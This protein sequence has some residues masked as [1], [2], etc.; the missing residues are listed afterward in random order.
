M[1]AKDTPGMKLGWQD[2][3][4]GEAELQQD[5]Q[6]RSQPI[7]QGATGKER[8]YGIV[9]SGSRPLHAFICQVSSVG[10]PGRCSNL[11]QCSMRSIAVNH[12]QTIFPATERLALKRGSGQ[13]TSF[14]Y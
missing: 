13:N 3:A 4:E 10:S 14:Y 8:P 12:K 2:G 11:E 1:F 5:S 6:L 9:P 7:L